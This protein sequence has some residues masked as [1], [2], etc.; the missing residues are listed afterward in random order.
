MDI[1]EIRKKAKAQAK[2][3]AEPQIE[4]ETFV[5]TDDPARGEDLVLESAESGQLPHEVQDEEVGLD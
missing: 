2:V 5:A 1:A 4:T 3:Q